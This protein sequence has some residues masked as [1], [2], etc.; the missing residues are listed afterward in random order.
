VSLVL[1]FRGAPTAPPPPPPPPP[2][3]DV[4]P[5]RE[6]S[7]GPGVTDEANIN[8]KP[9]GQ[10]WER[11]G[12]ER[13]RGLVPEGIE[14]SCN[15]WG[16]DTLSFTLKAEAGG[17]RP[18]LLPYTPVE[19]EIGGVIC[20]AGFI[21]TRPSDTNNYSVSCRGWQYA[22]DFFPYDRAYVHTRL[23]DYQDQRSKL[24]ADLTV[25]RTSGTVSV[26]QGVITL[27]WPNGAQLGA[28]GARV[29]V[30]MDLGPNSTGKRVIMEWESSNND[31]NSTCTVVGSDGEA[32]GSVGETGISF[33][34]DVG[35]SGTAG[36]TFT[37]ARRYIHVALIR[38]GTPLA[39]VTFRIKAMR[40]FRDTTYESATLSVLRADTLVK[41]ALTFATG[42]GN[43]LNADT[44]L[45]QAGTF[46][47]PEYVT[48]GY[49]TPRQV[50]EGV[51]AY[52]N[53]RLKIGGGDLRTVVFDPK[54]SV[55][56]YEVGEWSGAAFSD[57][58]MAGD[59]IY[60][61][62]ITDA[63]GP[64]GARVVSA[65]TQ[66][67]T[68]V[69]RNGF[70][71]AQVLSVGSAVTSAVADRFA[72]LW[73]A[74]HR[75]APFSGTLALTGGGARALESGNTVPPYMLLLAA[76][77][78]IRF[79]NQLDPDSNGWGRDGR[80]AGVTYNHDSKIAN[81]SISNQQDRF[82]KVLA[83]FGVLAAQGQ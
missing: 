51:N 17:R 18:D 1:L 15:D 59:D 63:S 37:T 25:F 4:L 43:L 75:A 10:G 61:Y 9:L 83:R 16:P 35:T 24:T 45:V 27:G 39:D 69:D 47:I 19:L 66:T 34:L 65:R 54:P 73:L 64:D 50:M 36:G 12:S 13:L 11:L 78:L 52:E 6:R 20:W 60:N 49:Q 71:R 44:S 41:D 30:T 28:G 5:K 32:Y 14:A 82:E 72:D 57:S 8:V 31:S 29:G 80:I 74:E 42:N 76:G 68:L 2:V 70:N 58:T 38:S 53:Y 67:S 62:A 7:G 79:Q 55:P 22:L 48:G 21:W 56:R 23:S 40:V 26:D 33:T 3:V 46:S 77:E 81:V